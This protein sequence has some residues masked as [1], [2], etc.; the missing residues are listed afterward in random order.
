MSHGARSPS[1]F[2]DAVAERLPRRGRALDIAGGAGRNAV[3]LAARG[4]EVTVADIS[5]VGLRQ[6]K[7][8]ASQ[9]GLELDTMVLDAKV[10]PLP[11][12]PWDV[13]VC[14]LFLHRPMFQAIP[15][16]LTAG[17]L[18]LFLQPTLRNL[19]RHAKPPARFLLREGELTAL[20]P[21]TLEVLHL[22][23]GWTEDGHHEARLLA[24]RAPERVG[25]HEPSS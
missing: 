1:P 5:P 12:G 11:A 18:F 8:R 17:G 25:Q 7:E 24:R 14:T 3:W 9:L 10:D 4:L 16:I 13:I 20:V 23:E 21:P 19:E 15:D 22:E 2:L 6:A